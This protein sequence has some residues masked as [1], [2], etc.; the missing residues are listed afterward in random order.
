MF[1]TNKTLLVLITVGF[2]T[3]LIP[4]MSSASNK[5]IGEM[6]YDYQLITAYGI[7]D[8]RCRGFSDELSI[9]KGCK[10]R[11][12]VGEILSELNIGPFKK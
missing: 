12:I 5:A 1:N 3:M 9:T 11:D 8:E 10:A 7:L 4:M 2:A 6:P